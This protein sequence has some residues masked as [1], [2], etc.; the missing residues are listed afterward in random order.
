MNNLKNLILDKPYTYNGRGNDSWKIFPNTIF[1]NIE[2]N[3]CDKTTTGTCERANSLSKCIEKCKNSKE[4][5]CAAGYFI[6]LNDEG[7]CVPLLLYYKDLND[8]YS[9]RRKDIYPQLEDLDVFSYINTDVLPFPPENAN[10]VFFQDIFFIQCVN[11]KLYLELEINSGRATFDSLES[12][13]TQVLPIIDTMAENQEYF[14]VM[15]NIN[16]TLNIPGTTMLL[17]ENNEK[18]ASWLPSLV[19]SADTKNKIKFV[20]I[21]KKEKY[22]YYG[23]SV[24]IVY[25]DVYYL[26]VNKTTKISTFEYS[27]VQKLKDQ[28]KDY[29]YKLIPN[30]DVYYCKNGKTFSVPLKKAKTENVKA[31]YKGNLLYKNPVCW[32]ITHSH[33]EKKNWYILIVVFILVFIPILLF[34]LYRA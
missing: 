19:P 7:I 23:Q 4:G 30:F 21:N 3:D 24:Y 31:Y 16:Y 26:T 27:S 6:K 25:E 10:Q 14:P 32:G 20:P 2:L 34:Y 12:V 18:D 9:L 22:L 17:G 13:R 1:R 28:G 8:T 15:P 11:S 29:I 33:E 5:P